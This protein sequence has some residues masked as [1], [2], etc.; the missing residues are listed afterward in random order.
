MENKDGVPMVDWV[1]IALIGFALTAYT[2]LKLFGHSDP[3]SD[4][5]LLGIATFFGGSYARSKTNGV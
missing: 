1:H 3:T 5:S 2:I 4:S